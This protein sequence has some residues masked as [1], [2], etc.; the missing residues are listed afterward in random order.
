MNTVER[1]KKICKDRNIPIS[2][3]EK[4]VGFGNGYIGQLKKGVMPDDRLKT[5]ADYLNVG[6]VY[7]VTGKEPEFTLEMAEIDVELSNMSKRVKEYAIRLNELSNDKQ[8][9][10]MQLIDML[11]DKEE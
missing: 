3:L 4:D 11:E 6:I 7:L 9:H 2:K 8:E 1:I 5:V 10:I